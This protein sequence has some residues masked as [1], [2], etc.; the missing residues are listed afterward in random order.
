MLSPHC[1]L[2]FWGSGPNET[3]LPVTIAPQKFYDN[4]W[5]FIATGKNAEGSCLIVEVI[6]AVAPVSV[7]GQILAN[8]GLMD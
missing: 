3:Q 8:T 7:R 2:N 1:A 5:N 4:K 6:E